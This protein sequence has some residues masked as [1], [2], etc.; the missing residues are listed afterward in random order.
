MGIGY[1]SEQENCIQCSINELENTSDADEEDI[2]G[3]T[4]NVA[5]FW[6][7]VE[8]KNVVACISRSCHMRAKS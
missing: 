1:E 3:D 4:V 5:L 2:Y 6:E 8:K 7:K